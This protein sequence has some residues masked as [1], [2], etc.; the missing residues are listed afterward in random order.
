[1][2]MESRRRSIGFWV[3]FLAIVFFGAAMMAHGDTITRNSGVQVLDGLKKYYSI[4][5]F[6]IGGEYTVG[7]VGSYELGGNGGTTLESLGEA[8]L[9]VAYIAVGTPKRDK[10]GKIINA[11]LVNP[12]YSGDAAFDYFFWYEGQKGTGFAKG[13]VVGPGKLIDTDKFYVVFLDA[14]GL[15][16]T[17]KPSGGLGMKF[18]RYSFMD[19][20]QANYRLLKDELGVGRVKLATGVSMGAMQSYIWAILHPEFVEAIMPIGGATASDPVVRWL[21]QNMSAAMKSDPAWMKAKGD[22]YKL[23]KDKHPNKGMMF[24]WSILGQSAFTFDFRSKQKWDKVKAD[25]F[26]WEPKDGAGE[27][28][29]K[30]ADDFDVNDLLFRNMA[31]ETY[32]INAYLSA[33]K[34]KTLILHVKSDQWLMYSAAEEAAKKIPGAKFAAFDSPLAHYAIFRAPNVLKKEVTEFLKEI[35][36]E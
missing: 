12:Y 16:G 5:N 31:I 19:M 3:A 14:V 6:R 35:G 28:L 22:Y 34:A 36:M 4:P 29:A 30:K 8:P 1:M 11:V 32:D 2:R 13:A 17:S 10:D 24:G 26:Y 9:K 21:F 27:K 7:N 18:P 15:W 20:V 25:V 33:I 23:P